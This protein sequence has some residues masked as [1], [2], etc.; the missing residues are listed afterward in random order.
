MELFEFYGIPKLCPISFDYA[1]DAEYFRNSKVIENLINLSDE[2]LYRFWL[3][4]GFPKGIAPNAPIFLAPYLGGLPYPLA[5]DWVSF[6]RKT[7]I[8][9]AATRSEALVALFNEHANTIIPHADLLGQDAPW[10]LERI[11]RRALESG[12]IRKAIALLQHSL[13]LSPSAETLCTLGDAYGGAGNEARALEAFLASTMHDRAPLRAFL[14]AAGCHAVRKEFSEAFAVLRKAYPLWRQVVDF[15]RKLDDVITQYFDSSSAE[16]HELYKHSIEHSDFASRKS[17]DRLL[18]ETL[19]EIRSIYLE[20]GD[21]PS[22]FE[23]NPDGYVSVLANDDIRQCT[24]YRVEQKKYQF[25]KAGIELRIFSHSDVQGFIDSL[26]GARSAIFYR[27]AATPDILKAILLS[28]SLNIDTYYEIDDL[29]FDADHY[30]DP[31][32][33]FEGQISLSDYAGLQFGVPLF[34]Y[35]MQMCR[36]SIAS[37]PALAERMR[38]ATGSDTSIVIRNGLDE[39]NSDTIMIGSHPLRKDGRLRLFYGSGTKAH[40][41]D[42][43]NLL[44][45]ALVNLM[46]RYP[47]VDLVIVGHL[48]LHPELSRMT[49]RVFNYPFT[50]D[51]KA[52]WS[53][54]ASC[55][56]NLAVLA[57]GLTADCKSEIKWLEAAVLQIPSVVSATRTYCEIIEHGVDGFVVSSTED[58]YDIL[59][60]L[61]EQPDLRR[62]IGHRA[63]TKALR[64]YSVEQGARTIAATFGNKGIATRLPGQR[65]L[66]VLICNVFFAPQSY[67]GATRVVE[68][69]V[70]TFQERYDE[71]EIGI[72]CSNES[73]A[74]TGSLKLGSENG[75]PVYR[76]STPREPHMDWRPFNDD[77]AAPFES[78][79]DHF[80]PDLIHFHCIQR[81][82]ATIV[83]VALKRQIPYLVTLHDAWWISDYQFLVDDDGLLRTSG[84]D[85]LAD[86]AQS[87]NPIASIDRRQRLRTLLAKSEANL[88][89]SEPFARIYQNAGIDRLRIV[90]NGVP[91]IDRVAHSPRHDGRVALGHLGGRSAHKG[92]ALIEAALRKGQFKNLHLTMVDG[93]LPPGQAADTFWGTTPVTLTAPYPQSQ[94]GQLYSRL[95]VL[96]APST[97]PESFGLVTREALSSHVRVVASNLGAIGQGISNG[98]NGWLIDV[99][100][101]KGLTE[102]LR[103][104][105]S[106]PQKYR[107]PIAEPHTHLRGTDEQ[108]ADLHALYHEI[109]DVPPGRRIAPEA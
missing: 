29:I 1:F 18:T 64:E 15:E 108:A 103:I 107:S 81:L 89:V 93:T 65:R 51:I 28:N 67:G 16:A 31:Y 50:P 23:N 74:R 8:S 37:T 35:A 9:P 82:S 43:N 69:N 72:F 58:W 63:R 34:R 12:D 22:S 45:P 92:A 57:P 41:A 20:M 24:H 94:M 30:P 46:H 73:A 98:L 33:S 99:S 96:L 84:T 109:A 6:A 25:Q 54:L 102:V 91:H 71:L 10:L 66:R 4:E 32:P 61:I 75:I 100:T 80:R 36:S 3:T 17:A 48:K 55:D 88:S 27:V 11:G 38:L 7:K 86:C 52:Y 44:G 95:D 77:H 2:D 76:L 106:A 70:R 47:G 14:Q 21:F 5:F 26:I 87:R 97:W 19:D 79:L 85:I 60:L 83:E 78:V 62:Q 105:D 39:R 56:V 53:L 90:E 13:S 101:T 68:D 42:F 104:I 49:E 59:R 40:N